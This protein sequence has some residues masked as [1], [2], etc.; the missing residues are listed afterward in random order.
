LSLMLDFA[1]G[2]IGD[3]AG[4]GLGDLVNKY[5]AAAVAKGLKKIGFDD[6]K[7]K[8]LTGVIENAFG[9][10]KHA[11]EYGIDTYGNL[12]KRL[13]GTGLEA[14]HVVEKRFAQ[15]LGITDQKLMKSVA[16]TPDEHQI[17]TNAWRKWVPYGTDYN[18]LTKAQIWVAAQDIYKGF[19]DILKAVKQTIYE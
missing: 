18:T 15:V 9:N 10:L 3:L 8:K 16:L 11:S 12:A 2:F 14:H 19:P 5:G 13:K 6:V 1:T 17:F 4:G 7:I